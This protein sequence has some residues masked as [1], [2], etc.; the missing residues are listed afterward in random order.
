VAVTR[1]R[2]DT[3][4]TYCRL[5]RK[6]D[7]KLMSVEEQEKNRSVD[8]DRRGLT[9]TGTYFDDGIS[10]FKRRASATRPGFNDLLAAIERGGLGYVSMVA[11]DR[12]DRSVGRLVALVEACQDRDVKIIM[13][14][15]VLDPNDDVVELYQDGVYAMQESKRKSERVLAARMRQLELGLYGGGKKAFGY[16]KPDGAAPGYWVQD[17]DEAKVIREGAR[18]VLDG[19]SLRVVALRWNEISPREPG[20]PWT[21]TKVKRTLL[22]PIVA[23]LR[24]HKGE[25]VGPLMRPDGTP[26]PAILTPETREEIRSVLASRATRRPARWY[27]PRPGLLSGIVTCANCGNSLTPRRYADTKANRDSYTCQ[28]DGGSRCGTI[29]VAMDRIDSL[30]SETALRRLE[31]PSAAMRKALAKPKRSA[32]NRGEDPDVLRAELDD[33][34]YSA[35]RGELPVRDFLTIR[36]PLQERLDR[37][38]I[39]VVEADDR[40][41]LTPLLAPGVDVRA[42][43]AVRDLD[44]KRAILAAMIEKVVINPATRPGRFDPDRVD[45]TWRVG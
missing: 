40:Q 23:G 11:N 34:T 8:A 18:M 33:L 9:V 2:R 14:D 10:G 42:E 36:K 24:A 17:P 25:P 32:T 31:K 12:C 6:K 5:S 19:K 4:A 1:A 28:V 41:V 27:T 16:V 3:V 35:A 39:V 38:L 15:K 30:V 43:W 21:Q 37:A 7:R 13:G 20:S 29:G 44:G 26:W 45:I 22:N